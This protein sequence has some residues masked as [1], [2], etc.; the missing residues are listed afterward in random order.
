MS[1]AFV[2]NQHCCLS[3]VF[4]LYCSSVV[5]CWYLV[6]LHMTPGR[7]QHWNQLFWWRFWWTAGLLLTAGMSEVEAT[8]RTCDKL[9][10]TARPSLS[11][12]LRICRC[13]RDLVGLS[14]CYCSNVPCVILDYCPV[15]CSHPQLQG[16]EGIRGASWEGGVLNWAEMRFSGHD[17]M[18]VIQ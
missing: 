10:R 1:D 6:G 16:C 2:L 4:W 9:S 5:K 13:E 15:W 14:K 3:N 7:N 8:A 12:R 17:G 11:T 18:S